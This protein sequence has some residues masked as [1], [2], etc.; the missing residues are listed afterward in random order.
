MKSKYLVPIFALAALGVISLGTIQAM[1]H[2]TTSNKTIAKKISEKFNLP[3]ND[4]QS[5]FDEHHKEMKASVQHRI[6]DTL[7]QAVADGKLTE[8]QKQKIIAKQ[9]EIQAQ[10]EATRESFKDM[11]PEER[12]QTKEKH[13]SD[14]EQ[15]AKD[16]GIDTQYLI[17]AFHKGMRKGMH[18]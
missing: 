11:T 2:D 12:K 8:D 1:A 15:W 18:H 3:E 16:N 4:V 14:L 9:Q 13:R 10:H 5:V 6:E 7:T 17:G